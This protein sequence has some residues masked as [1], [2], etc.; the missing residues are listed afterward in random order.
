MNALAPSSRYSD[1]QLALI[2]RTIAADLGG[3]EFDMF[4][5][6]CRRN[7]LDPFRSQASPI[8]FNAKNADKRRVALVVGIDGLR[9]IADRQDTYAPDEGEPEY[10]VDESLKGP[11]NP[12]GIVKCTVYVNKL[13]ANRWFR[14]PGVAFWD[15]FAPVTDE[16]AWDEQKG[17]RA[18]TGKKTLSGKW[19]DMPRHMIAIAAE[20]QAL[21]KGWP[22]AFNDLY[23]P[24]EVAR[25][26]EAEWTSAS[27][28]V[29]RKAAGERVAKLGGRRITFQ[30]DPQE[31]L[32]GWAPGEVAD[33]VME[34]LEGC[35]GT[36]KLDWFTRT[37]SEALKQFWGE[38]QSEALEVKR[39]IERR[40]EEL[41]RTE[42]A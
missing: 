26:R 36:A 2:R 42:A 33:R 41:S 13:R 8:V 5:E 15:E 37:N 32:V 25:T 19:A 14:T 38:N 6:L 31:P 30:T 27:E 23:A 17:K 9:A 35:G 4:I 1:A 22:D 11:A 10:E 3:N 40:H 28:A 21:R 18:P 24:E 34:W 29:E 12:H 39:A 16:W 20:R 7:G